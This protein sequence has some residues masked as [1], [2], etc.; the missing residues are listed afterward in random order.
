MNTLNRKQKRK[1]SQGLGDTI[2]KIT[3][4]TGIKAAVK[5]V[6]GE[7]CG[8]EER[9][10]KL[11]ALFPRRQP[12]CMSETEYNWWTAF[13]ERNATTIQPDELDAISAMYSRIFQKRKVYR[14]CTCNPNAWQEVINH[15]NYIYDTY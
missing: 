8:C 4:S 2:E 10:V 1:P 9:K 5:F 15:L 3:E 7:D 13:R 14:P 11:N 12:L 6:A